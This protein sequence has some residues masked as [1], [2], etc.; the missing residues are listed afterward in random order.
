MIAIRLPLLGLLVATA[1]AQDIAPNR[2]VPADAQ[3]VMRMAAPT[4]W[5]AEFANTKIA[6]VFTGEGL[7]PLMG[8][9]MEGFDRGIAEMKDEGVDPEL[10]DQLFNKYTGDIVV[11]VRIDLED[12][13]FAMEE[14]RQPQMALVLA[15]SPDGSFDLPGLSESLTKVLEEK[16]GNETRDVVVGDY[17]LAVDMESDAQISFPKMIDDHLVMVFASDMETM[18]PAML[19]SDNRSESVGNG[20]PFFVHI[21]AEQALGTVLDFISEQLDNDPNAPPID[22]SQVMT[23]L[24]LAAL[25]SLDITLSADGEQAVLETNLATKSQNHGLLGAFLLDQGTPKTLRYLPESATAFACQA[26]DLGALYEAIGNMWTSMEA[27]MPMAFEDVELAFEDATKVR[28]RED[29]LDH[30]GSE[31]LYLADYDQAGEFENDGPEAA[32]S[33]FFAGTCY[34]LSLRDGKAFG[35]SLEKTLRSRGLHAARKSDEYQGVKVYRLRVGGIF[36]IEYSVTD[37][38][39]LLALGSDES[40]RTQLRSILDARANPTV[41]IPDSISKHANKIPAGWNGIGVTPIGSLME[42]IGSMMEE[43]APGEMP[44]EAEMVLQVM[45][46]I[47]KE[48]KAVGLDDAVQFTWA[49][50][51]GIRTITRL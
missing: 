17:T 34:A 5:A 15:L 24:G 50:K 41:G 13:P 28:L 25:K 7:A 30:I 3:L 2:F 48:M 45:G 4:K 47:G 35:E 29:L 31:V 51:G 42:G 14:D 38:L 36:E 12:L 44:P 16:N 22:P 20:M 1:A 26:F 32:I 10:L 18:G 6:Q 8:Q 43:V 21:D 37:D 11:S 27:F 33:A 19:A 39:L 9:F 49:T 46:M 23:D 40:S